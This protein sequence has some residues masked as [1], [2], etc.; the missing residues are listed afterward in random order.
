MA[1]ASE[2]RLLTPDG[3][4]LSRFVVAANGAALSGNRL[5]VDGP[6]GISVYDTD[7][8]R[9]VAHVDPVG[10]LADLDGGILVTETAAEVTLRRL[11]DG[12]R[13]TF[14]VQG[15]AHAQLERP[16][17]FL[18]GARGISFVPRRDILRRLGR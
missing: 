4:V 5:A 9:R 12:R 6:G 16:G 8:G 18:A 17:L 3:R 15:T 1:S 14:A 11:A 7:S 10:D 2:V 13:T